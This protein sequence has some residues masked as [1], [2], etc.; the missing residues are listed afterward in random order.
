MPRID[1]RFMEH[2][3]SINPYV[4]LVK[5]RKMSFNTEKY[6]AI[7]TEVNHLLAVNFIKEAHY[8]KLPSNV[9]LEKKSNDK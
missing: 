1:E 3:L 8:A 2:Q 7:A 5:Q 4:W 9:V 6:A